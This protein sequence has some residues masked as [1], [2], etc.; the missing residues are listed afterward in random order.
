[1][2]LPLHTSRL[3]NPASSFP[4][5]PHS[6]S[7]TQNKTRSLS[8]MKFKLFPILTLLIVSVARA[9]SV[10]V[11]ELFEPQVNGPGV[12]KFDSGGGPASLFA[13]SGLSGPNGL[14]FDSSGN[15]FVCNF[16]N[17]TI[18]RFDSSG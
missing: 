2:F 16:G 4:I 3:T 11:S 14:T 13:G 12:L 7:R 5:S 6:E 15:L 10:Y 1:M 9:D 18:A 8:Q 17:N